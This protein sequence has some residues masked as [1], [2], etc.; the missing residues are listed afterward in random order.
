MKICPECGY[1]MNRNSYFKKYICTREKCQYT[2]NI[3][4]RNTEIA[5]STIIDIVDIL[6]DNKIFNNNEILS[7]CGDVIKELKAQW[8][9]DWT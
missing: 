6:L 3:D 5:I 8:N 4:E 9:S 2:H 7:G 1:V